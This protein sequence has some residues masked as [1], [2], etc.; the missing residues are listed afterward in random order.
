[1]DADNELIQE[2]CARGLGACWL[3]ND[4]LYTN[5]IDRQAGSTKPLLVPLQNITA[6]RNGQLRHNTQNAMG[7][8]L[9]SLA[10]GLPD[11]AI[12]A[13]LRHFR[14]DESDNPGRGN[15]FEHD[16]VQI[17]VDFAHNE[18]GLQALADSILAMGAE[19]VVLMFGQ[20]GDR[21]DD[22]IRSQ[23]RVCCSMKP[24]RL[25]VCAMPGYERGRGLWDV[26][27]VIREEA[28]STGLENEKIELFDSLLS[29]AHDALSQ[30]RHGDVL[31]LLALT[32]RKEIL[33][34]IHG[35]V[36]G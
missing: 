19:R 36:N 2:Q 14:G 1:M 16:G 27:E 25:L 4:A 21:D 26:S 35:F 10:L 8:C 12:R 6:S 11:E 17:L 22:L 7:A 33:E 31:V 13:G 24:G 30:S 9:V 18:H 32:Q 20:A 5:I 34:L 29:A 23:T 28:L 3:E 15:W